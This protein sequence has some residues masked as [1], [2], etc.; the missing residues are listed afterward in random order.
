M[1]RLR[2]TMRDLED[3]EKDLGR[4]SQRSFPEVYVL[5]HHPSYMDATMSWFRLCS[6]LDGLDMC[7]IS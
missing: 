5:E 1:T 7:Y 2:L 6:E 3:I 4:V